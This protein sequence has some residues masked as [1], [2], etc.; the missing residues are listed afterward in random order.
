MN[1][2]LNIG[3]D[4]VKSLE[5]DDGGVYPGAAVQLSG[6]PCTNDLVESA[7]LRCCT[8]DIDEYSD[9]SLASDRPR[10]RAGDWKTPE[11]KFSRHGSRQNKTKN[12]TNSQTK[13]IVLCHS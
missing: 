13:G 5:R 12:K 8:S 10:Y 2:R 6:I 11:L 7:D 4:C 1:R 9:S 3:M